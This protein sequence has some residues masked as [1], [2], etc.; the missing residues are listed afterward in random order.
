MIKQTPKKT[1]EETMKT[2]FLTLALLM[3]AG[4]T[5]SQSV[6][7]LVCDSTRLTISINIGD[8]TLLA[9]HDVDSSFA[10]TTIT[11]YASSVEADSY[12]PVFYADTIQTLTVTK[13]FFVAIDPKVTEG[14][15]SLKIYSSGIEETTYNLIVRD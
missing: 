14:I 12:S 3:F 4:V 8:K 11:L 10:G 7:P 15:L 9:I 13:G 1:I 6:M 2:L 5:Y